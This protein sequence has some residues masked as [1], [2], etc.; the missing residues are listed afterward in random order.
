M[1]QNI[2]RRKTR[3]VKVGSVCVG[4]THPIAIQSMAKTKTAHALETAKQIRMLTEAGCEIVRLA[5]KDNKDAE[6]ITKIK[7]L[8]S[9]ALVADIHFDWRLA[10]RAIECGADKIRLN[11]GNINKEEHIREVVRQ[12]KKAGIPIR[13]GLNS[14]SIRKSDTQVK[15]M[16]G[17][18]RRY[19]RIFEKLEFYDT[20]ISLKASDV[21]TTIEAYRRMAVLC[22]YPFHLGLTATGLPFKGAVQSSIAIGS[23]LLEGI[24]DTIRVSLTDDPVQEVRTARYILE[25]L[26]LRRFGPRIISCPTCGRCQV[27]LVTIV[28]KLERALESNQITRPFKI[29]VM[30]CE[31]NGPGE[32][33]DAD[34]GIAFG[35]AEGLLFKNGKPLKKVSL[36]KCITV[37]LEETRRMYD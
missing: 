33:M 28:K 26:D 36:G 2:E 4:G 18:C 35:R 29:A 25:A 22:D 19:L 7:K 13:I 17:S 14:G 27:D 23:L 15:V 20:V 31:V 37:L 34:I 6:A 3:V 5:V 21:C 11:P 9:V 10:L 1:A 32:A 12:A 24:G 30:G 16:V 8:V